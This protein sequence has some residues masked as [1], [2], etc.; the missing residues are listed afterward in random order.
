MDTSLARLQLSARILVNQSLSPMVTGRFLPRCPI[1]P[2]RRAAWKLCRQVA[3]ACN[4]CRRIPVFARA[5]VRRNEASKT[6]H[7]QQEG[8]PTETIPADPF[9]GVHDESPV[10]GLDAGRL[11][12]DKIAFQPNRSFALIAPIDVEHHSGKEVAIKGTF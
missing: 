12:A 11:A 2:L 7:A 1:R 8:C 3:D 9:C 4:A 6:S 5:R 10:L